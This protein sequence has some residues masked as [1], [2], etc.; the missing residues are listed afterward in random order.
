MKFKI[1]KIKN[2]I[3]N[4]K[5]KNVENF[6][7]PSRKEKDWKILVQTT[8]VALVIVSVW[9]IYLFYGVTYGTLFQSSDDFKITPSEFSR[10]EL[11]VVADGIQ[12]QQ[13]EFN[14]L[15]GI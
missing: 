8:I 6:G 13:D 4:R 3:K 10:E 11:S 9:C 7:A 15:I 12:K 2:L 1:P 5:I 14:R